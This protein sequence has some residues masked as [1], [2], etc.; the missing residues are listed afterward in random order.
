MVERTL[1]CLQYRDTLLFLTSGVPELVP[2]DV[3]VVPL[4]AAVAAAAV[5]ALARRRQGAARPPHGRGQR[6]RR[7]E[8]RLQVVCA[9]TWY[10]NLCSPTQV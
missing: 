7:L 3:R 1:T 8:A 10:R 5:A 9:Y 4:A 2:A 6:R